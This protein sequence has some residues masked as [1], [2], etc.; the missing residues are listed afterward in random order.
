MKPLSNTERQKRKLRSWKNE[1]KYEDF[2]KKKAEKPESYHVRNKKRMWQRKNRRL[3][4]WKKGT[5][6]NVRAKGERF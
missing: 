2:K 6:A 1:G 3:L 5:D 4:N